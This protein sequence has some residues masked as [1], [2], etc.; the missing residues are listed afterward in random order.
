MPNPFKKLKKYFTR[1]KKNSYSVAT[2][3]SATSPSATSP[4]KKSPSKKSPSLATSSSKKSPSLATSS[5]ATSRLKSQTVEKK[6]SDELLKKLKNLFNEYTEAKTTELETKKTLD[7]ELTNYFD[8]YDRETMDN[9]R[10]VLRKK[11][12][13]NQL[14]IRET[15]EADGNKVLPP[16]QKQTITDKEFIKNGQKKYCNVLKQSDTKKTLLLNFLK[17]NFNEKYNTTFNRMF[18]DILKKGGE[19]QAIRG[20]CK[21]M[22]KSF[23]LGFLEPKKKMSK[24]GK[25]NFKKR[26]SSRKK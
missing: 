6:P 16:T 17:K 3:P 15:F 9:G 18:A 24:K 12:K 23:A 4:S 5:L 22:D 13:Y 20:I 26:R 11:N 14:T 19:A 21:S 1:K 8:N 25:I 2:S 10:V 7:E